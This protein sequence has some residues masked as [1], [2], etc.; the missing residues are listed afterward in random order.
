MADDTLMSCEGF[1]LFTALQNSDTDGRQ[2]VMQHI[3]ELM[4]E[5]ARNTQIDLEDETKLKPYLCTLL[6]IS[7]E[8]PYEEERLK[9]QELLQDLK[10][11]YHI[12]I[13]K[14][15]QNRPSKFVDISEDIF[16]KRFMLKKGGRN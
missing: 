11:E 10:N 14:R 15:L 1:E 3:M 5:W 16:A 13:P 7:Y 8:C 9:C 12:D 2:N 4:C 6:R